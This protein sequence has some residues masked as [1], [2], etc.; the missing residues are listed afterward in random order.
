MGEAEGSEPLG[1]QIK[2][3]KEVNKNG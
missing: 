1:I 2:P 3:K